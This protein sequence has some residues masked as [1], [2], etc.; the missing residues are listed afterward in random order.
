MG[1]EELFS[2]I[3]NFD[4]SD[5]IALRNGI[6]NGLAIG[7]FAENGVL[8]IQPGGWN[9]GDEKLTSVC[10]G[11]RIG[12]GQQTWLGE[13]QRRSAF[14]FKSIARTA[15]SCAGWVAPLDH[16][17][18]DHTVKSEPVVKTA[19]GEVQEIGNGDRRFGGEQGK[20]NGAFGGGEFDS[21]ILHNLR[22]DTRTYC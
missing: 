3:Q 10:A 16:E 7:D 8:A 18:V 14:V 12:H 9:V 21:D 2:G 6:D 13:L 19:L 4:T 1:F 11:T 22:L 17:I 5:F 20:I 15:T